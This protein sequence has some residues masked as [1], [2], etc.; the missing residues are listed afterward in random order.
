[1]VSFQNKKHGQVR[2]SQ[3]DSGNSGKYREQSFYISE[4]NCNGCEKAEIS[5]LLFHSFNMPQV[6]RCFPFSEILNS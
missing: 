5:S 1:M 6:L 3:F 4:Y 2:K